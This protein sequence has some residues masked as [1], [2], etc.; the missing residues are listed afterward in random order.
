VITLEQ[1]TAYMY[2]VRSVY[3]TYIFDLYFVTTVQFGAFL[4]LNLMIAV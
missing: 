2:M 1:W 4:V 3:G